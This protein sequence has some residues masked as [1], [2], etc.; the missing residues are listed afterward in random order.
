MTSKISFFKLIREDFKRR[1]WLVALILLVCFIMLPVALMLDV[2]GMLSSVRSGYTEMKY[3][4]ESYQSWMSAGNERF[5]ILILGAAL[6]TGISGYGFLHSKVRLD[7]YHSLPIT[8]SK[9]FLVQYVSGILMFFIPFAVCTLLCLLVGAVNGLLTNAVAVHAVKVL[10]YHLLEFLTIYGTAILGMILTGKFLTAI[11]GVAV[12]AVY[13]PGVILELQGM[14]RMFFDTFVPCEKL[15]DY[16]L[17]FSPV[18][19]GWYTENMSA[20]SEKWAIIGIGVMVFWCLVMTG[21]SVWLYKIRRTE[22]AEHSMAFPKTEGVIKVLLV[23]P[24]SLAVGLYLQQVVTTETQYWFFAGIVCAVLILSAVIEFIYHMNMREIFKHKLQILLAGGITL[25]IAFCFRYDITGYD[26]YLPAKDNVAQMALYNGSVNGSSYYS[27]EAALNDTLVDDF[28]AIYALAEKG[29]RGGRTEEEQACSVYVEYRLK[30]GR[31]EMRSYTVSETDMDAAY[32]EL[33]QSQAF[34]EKMYP[35]LREEIDVAD[36][37]SINGAFGDRDLEIK[38]EERQEFLE[39]YKEELKS[40]RYEDVKN[41]GVATLRVTRTFEEKYGPYAVSEIHY[42]E[43]GYPICEGFT[44]TIAFLKDRADIDVK[45][46]FTAEDVD[47]IQILD[48]R[49]EKNGIWNTVTDKEQIQE[50]LDYVSYFPWYIRGA[51][52]EDMNVYIEL[53]NG[54][55]ISGRFYFKKGEVPE[56]LEEEK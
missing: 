10:L 46:L 39:I 41:N 27:V 18:I 42:T 35:L 40:I 17:L 32:E 24:L 30:S 37:M 51:D 31:R 6:A 21:L 16:L 1:S 25:A 29:A 53:N 23:I 56:F 20:R 54:N 50:I 7:F 3:V 52:V 49:T 13:I 44:N 48:Y 34:I 19:S 43:D 15:A 2:D 22:A 8:R 36:T 14:K 5:T 11:L 4:A 47:N 26:T 45:E 33:F 55:S 12:L 38:K 28:D 9:F